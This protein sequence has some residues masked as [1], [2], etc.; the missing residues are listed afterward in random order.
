MAQSP[1]LGAYVSETLFS[2]N[3]SRWKR[4]PQVQEAAMF[5]TGAGKCLMLSAGLEVRRVCRKEDHAGV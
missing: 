4:K 2:T 5:H 3:Q 1:G